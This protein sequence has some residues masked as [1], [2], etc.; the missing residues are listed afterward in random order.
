MPPDLKALRRLH[1]FCGC[2]PLCRA[3]AEGQGPRREAVH[4]VLSYGA[5]HNLHSVARRELARPLGHR[6]EHMHV[7]VN[8]LDGCSSLFTHLQQVSLSAAQHIG[9]LLPP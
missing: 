2:I 5:L 6:Q 7:E 3:L 4:R 9:H 1:Q 8:P